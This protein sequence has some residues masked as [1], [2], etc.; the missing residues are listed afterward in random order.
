MKKKEKN[1]C[2]FLQIDIHVRGVKTKTVIILQKNIVLNSNVKWGK[3]AP[4]IT[5]LR[6]ILAPSLDHMYP[7]IKTES[8]KVCRWEIHYPQFL[9]IDC[10][11]NVPSFKV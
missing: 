6:K 3:I 7:P 10:V 8:R 5:E 1:H 4:K 9:Q 11:V 2:L